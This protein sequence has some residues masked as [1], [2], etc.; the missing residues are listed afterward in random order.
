MF[1]IQYW[2]KRKR[3]LYKEDFLCFV[4]GCK[5]VCAVHLRR[6]VNGCYWSFLQSANPQCT[7]SRG[8]CGT[9]QCGGHKG[10]CTSHTMAEKYQGDMPQAHL[11]NSFSLNEP[12]QLRCTMHSKIH[13]K[14]P[15]SLL[16]FMLTTVSKNPSLYA[17]LGR[18][19]WVPC[20]LICSM[21]EFKN[22]TT[23]RKNCA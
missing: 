4:Y 11:L 8:P 3:N 15:L 18:N 1:V 12:H 21:S 17:S 6:N 9:Q 19:R 13:T 23:C 22:V 14:N 16:Q 2:L 5:C 10:D 20:S 7:H